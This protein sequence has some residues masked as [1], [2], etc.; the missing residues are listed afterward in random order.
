MKGLWS[1]H[2]RG[3]IVAAVLLAAVSTCGLL[4]SRP[5]SAESGQALSI[6]PPLIE[7]KADPGQ[8]VKATI[9]LTNISSGELLIKTQF[10]DFGAKNETGEPNIIFDDA[11]NTPYSLRQWITTSAPFKIASKESKTIDFPIQVPKNAEPGGHYAVI[12][13]TGG[14]PELEDSGVALSASIGSLVLLDVSGNIQEKA[15]LSDF[16]AATPSFAKANFFEQGPIEFVQR[17]QNEGNIHVKPTGTVDIYDM[18][19]HKVKSLQVN[20]DLSDKNN[21]PKSVL[22]QSIRRFDEKWDQGWLLGK[23][24]AKLNLSYGDGKKLTSTLSFWV[25][26]YKLVAVIIIGLIALFFGL[27]F[28]IRRYNT[29]IISKSRRM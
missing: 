18:W 15:S 3:R 16:Y 23:Y 11:A 2:Y 20:G 26:P 7:L 27:R 6:S 10:N 17:I 28:G 13:F 1:G 8:T 4:M 25:V 22:P 24:E 5:V 19:G 29:H 9:K 14:A 12:R 21:P